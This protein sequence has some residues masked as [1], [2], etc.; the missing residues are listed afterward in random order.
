M[1]RDDAVGG[2]STSSGSGSGSGSSQLIGNSFI[3]QN[4][5]ATTVRVGR[6]NGGGV[7]VVVATYIIHLSDI[8]VM[9][10]MCDD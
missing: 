7:V 4:Y 9:H 6:G 5:W 2:S 8:C 3:R 10:V 1:H